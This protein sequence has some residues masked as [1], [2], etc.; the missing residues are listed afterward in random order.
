MNRLIIFF[1]I[2]V[3]LSLQAERPKKVK[4]TKTCERGM[5][6]F[7]NP[8]Y[9]ELDPWADLKKKTRRRSKNSAQNP[10]DEHFSRHVS[11][12]EGDSDLSNGGYGSAARDEEIY[13]K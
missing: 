5:A 4:T 3:S 9:F 2:L 7:D 12:N 1:V 6:F 10:S 8:N 13:F 11:S